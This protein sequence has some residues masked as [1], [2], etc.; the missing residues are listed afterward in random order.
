[1]LREIDKDRQIPYDF[2]YRWNLKKPK[3]MNKQNKTERDTW[4]QRIN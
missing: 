1:M 2:T 3:Q 4:I